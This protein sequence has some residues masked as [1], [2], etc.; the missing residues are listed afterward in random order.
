MSQKT[1]QAEI[2]A[3]EWDGEIRVNL[4]QGRSHTDYVELWCSKNGQVTDLL[5]E[6]MGVKTRG[7]FRKAGGIFIR[8]TGAGLNKRLHAIKWL[9]MY[10]GREIKWEDGYLVNL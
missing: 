8:V 2:K 7:P 6:A 1:A 3:I 10:A 4:V 9:E 5:A